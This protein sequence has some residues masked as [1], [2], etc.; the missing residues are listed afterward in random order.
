MYKAPIMFFTGMNLEKQRPLN[1]QDFIDIFLGESVKNERAFGEIPVFMQ[2][3]IPFSNYMLTL[4]DRSGRG[5]K[6]LHPTHMS[7]R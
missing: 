1:Q 2:K 4:K 6:M 3:V 7:N 5:P